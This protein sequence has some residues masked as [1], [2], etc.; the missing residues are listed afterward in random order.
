[1]V[2]DRYKNM[3]TGYIC[4][5]LNLSWWGDPEGGHSQ[6]FKIVPC[7]DWQGCPEAVYYFDSFRLRQQGVDEYDNDLLIS[8]Y[9]F[10]KVAT[11]EFEIERLP[12]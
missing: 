11:G 1:M 3:G 7:K 4:K 5:Q 9:L 2:K 12:K 10:M 6:S 8:A